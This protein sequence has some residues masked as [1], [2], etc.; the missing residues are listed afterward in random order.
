MK[1]LK[2]NKNS[3]LIELEVMPQSMTDTVRDAF[4]RVGKRAQAECEITCFAGHGG[5]LIFAKQKPP[6]CTVYRFESFENMLGGV[7][8]VLH[9]C[10]ATSTLIYLEDAYF[11]ILSEETEQLAEF[12]N[13]M[14]NPEKVSAYLEEHGE[15]LCR[16]DAV[17]KL[18][19]VFH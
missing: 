4:S 12:G 2:I 1:I 3:L 18:A 7:Q 6:A 16:N 9:N 8:E 19:K 15:I 17:Q 13:V 10:T 5:V 11:L 14:E